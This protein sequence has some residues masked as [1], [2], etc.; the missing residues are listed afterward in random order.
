MH[1]IWDKVQS[2]TH[3][4]GSENGRTSCGGGR[5]TRG[6]IEPLALGHRAILVEVWHLVTH[7]DADL[8][9]EQIMTAKR[10]KSCYSAVICDSELK[11]WQSY[12]DKDPWW[13]SNT[14]QK[15]TKNLSLLPRRC[16]PSLGGAKRWKA[17]CGYAFLLKATNRNL[18]RLIRLTI[19]LCLD[20]IV[21]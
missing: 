2:K 9:H 11:F 20:R 21:G 3:P 7:A 18:S 17:K 1:F 13:R 15:Y 12:R 10:S 4:E 16:V 6:G 8:G 19:P 5:S 14:L